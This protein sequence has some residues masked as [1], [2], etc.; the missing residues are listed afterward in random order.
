MERDKLSHHKGI[1]DLGFPPVPYRVDPQ[2]LL[3]DIKRL[4]EIPL[5]RKRKL[6]DKR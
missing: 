4:S 1:P 6:K 5:V 3:N 2:K